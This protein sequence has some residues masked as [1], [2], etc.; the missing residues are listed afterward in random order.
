MQKDASFNL[1]ALKEEMQKKMD[2]MK[3]P[4]GN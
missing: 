2:Q 3:S 4:S 1:E